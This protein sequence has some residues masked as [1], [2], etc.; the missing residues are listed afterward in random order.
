MNDTSCQTD[1]R[2]LNLDTE[3]WNPPL[4]HT[5]RSLCV[6]KL[7]SCHV[8]ISTATG[9]CLIFAHRFSNRV[10]QRQVRVSDKQQRHAQLHCAAALCALARS[11]SP[12]CSLAVELCSLE[13]RTSDTLGAE[14]KAD[15]GPLMIGHF[16]APPRGCLFIFLLKSVAGQ[17]SLVLGV[18][19]ACCPCSV[20]VLLKQH[21]QHKKANLLGGCIVTG[22]PP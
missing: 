10:K 16:P 19:P 4:L 12:L 3:W 9:T 17:R 5:R 11:L 13:A 15:P 22:K 1:W 18:V 21:S 14:T 8:Q 20:P 7:F 6:R 2:E